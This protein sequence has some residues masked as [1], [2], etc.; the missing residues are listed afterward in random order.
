MLSSWLCQSPGPTLTRIP[1]SVIQLCCLGT[2]CLPLHCAQALPWEHC[3]VS[4]PVIP[5]GNTLPWDRPPWSSGDPKENNGRSCPRSPPG[6][7]YT[8]NC[9]VHSAGP[10]P[11]PPVLP[12]TRPCLVA[13]ACTHTFRPRN[14]HQSPKFRQRPTAPPATAGPRQED[15]GEIKPL[16]LW[17]LHPCQPHGQ[18]TDPWDRHEGAGTLK[19]TRQ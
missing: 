9:H 3:R 13:A 18:D 11:L 7:S 14:P 15:R 6:C 10:V 19:V 12:A 1:D 5:P 4:F 16:A 2:A 8:S 17:L